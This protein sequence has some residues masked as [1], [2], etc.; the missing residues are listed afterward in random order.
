MSG[1]PE[2]IIIIVIVIIIVTIIIIKLEEYGVNHTHVVHCKVLLLHPGCLFAILWLKMRCKR[3]T[4]TFSLLLGFWGVSWVSSDSI[5]KTFFFR[6][7]IVSDCRESK[8]P[9]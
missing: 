2:G 7:H 9:Y 1:L 4:C 6:K 8:S 3:R 5:V